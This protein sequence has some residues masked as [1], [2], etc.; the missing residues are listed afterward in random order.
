[1]PKLGLPADRSLKKLIGLVSLA[2][3]GIATTAL[4]QFYIKTVDSASQ[5]RL[6]AD[7]QII[8]LIPTESEQREQVAIFLLTNQGRKAVTLEK[9]TSTCTCVAIDNIAQTVIQPGE[10]FSLEFRVTLPDYG[11]ST[12]FIDVAYSTS[13]VPLRLQV[14]AVGSHRLPVISE[15]RNG[16]P[17]FLALRSPGEQVEIEIETLEALDSQ[18]WLS[19]LVC[20]LAAVK[21]TSGA[22]EES[23]QED[24]GLIERVYHYTI[25]WH[26]L[27]ST[28]EFAGNLRVKTQFG[29]E[30]TKDVGI[31]KGRLADSRPF[32][33]TVVLLSRDHLSETVLFKAGSGRWNISDAVPLPPWVVANWQITDG[34]PQLVISVADHFLDRNDTHTL[35]LE[36]DQGRVSELKIVVQ[37]N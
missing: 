1:M 21:V 28:T 5:A 17:V 8:R 13:K 22:V 36:N 15:I 23:I 11:T 7:Q 33:P 34:D 24:Q 29:E 32:S 37:P 25:S 9:V 14:E 27:P 20:D 30:P 10:A 6:V 3:L 16:S 2:L 19:E 26:S 12:T 31:V 18:A 4:T 35:V